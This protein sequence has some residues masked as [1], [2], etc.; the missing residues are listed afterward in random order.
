MTRKY[1]LDWQKRANYT[2][3]IIL[4]NIYSDRKW[5]SGDGIL[6]ADDKILDIKFNDN[7]AELIVK[8]IVD[9]Y[10]VNPVGK[11]LEKVTLNREDIACIKFYNYEK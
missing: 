1:W 7:Q 3:N 8:R 9:C 2:K 4:F 10:I 11:N 6:N 5:K